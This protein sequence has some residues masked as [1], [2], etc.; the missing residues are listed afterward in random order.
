MI[1]EALNKLLAYVEAEDYSGY[2]PYDTLNSWLPFHLIGKWGPI[3]ATQF[4]KRNPVN[5]RPLL[6]IKKERNPKGI[7]LFLHAYS[8]LYQQ[9]PKQE[10]LERIDSLLDWLEE[11]VSADFAGACWGYNFAW[12][13]PAKT[14]P[15]YTPSAVA[16]GF[17]CRGLHACYEATGNP[18]AKKLLYGAANFVLENLD[19]HEDESGIVFSYT[20]VM[21]DA[22][23]N[24]SLL[25]SEILARSDAITGDSNHS[26]LVEKAMRF[27]V[28]R[29]KSDGHWK[30]SL[31][32][33]SGHERT[34]TDFHQGYVLESLHELLALTNIESAEIRQAIASGLGFYHREQF[35]PDGRSKWRLPKIWPVEIHN[36]AQGIITFCRLSEYST[37][38]VAFA[39]DIANWTVSNMQSNDGSFHYQ[40]RKAYRIKIPYMRWSNAWMLLALVN[41]VGTEPNG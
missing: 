10:Y 22:C 29:Q 36:Q 2:D 13:G 23:Y 40:H 30:Y 28:C 32:L 9:R 5:L 31:D 6:G 16:S 34:Q 12:A 11:N 19:R 39:K 35:Y 17:V 27:V 14:I 20:P 4:Q 8:M 33:D 15:A 41:L 3:I 7:G 25:A 24:A 26:E 1:S 38:E 37:S 21:K 18:K